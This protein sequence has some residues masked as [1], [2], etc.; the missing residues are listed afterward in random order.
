M[1]SFDMYSFNEL[2]ISSVA[3][4]N[5]LASSG[6]G[7]NLLT[8][9]IYLTLSPSLLPQAD[10]S[11]HGGKNIENLTILASIIIRNVLT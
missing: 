8:N 5:Q 6:W 11:T 9:I 7:A 4:N 1:T 10:Q 3:G 2:A